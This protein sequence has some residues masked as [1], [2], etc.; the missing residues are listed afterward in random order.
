MYIPKDLPNGHKMPAHTERKGNTQPSGGLK[1][2]QGD[3]PL[4]LQRSILSDQSTL[5]KVQWKMWVL[6]GITGK[7]KGRKGER[8]ERKRREGEERRGV[9][10]GKEKQGTGKVLFNSMPL[11]TVARSQNTG[12]ATT[13]KYQNHQVGNFPTPLM[14]F[15][16]SFRYAEQDCKF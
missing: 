4:D 8:K 11:N 10:E 5:Q 13:S 15:S 1:M 9:G 3:L 16:P 2:T 14:P 12:S 6:P 7:R